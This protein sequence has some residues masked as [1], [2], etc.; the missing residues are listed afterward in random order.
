MSVL[1]LFVAIIAV[2]TLWFS[3]A[4]SNEIGEVATTNNKQLRVEIRFDDEGVN[5][6]DLSNLFKGGHLVRP[7][8]GSIDEM[9]GWSYR[10]LRRLGEGE[11]VI[12]R[13]RVGIPLDTGPRLTYQVSYEWAIKK[14]ATEKLM[15]VEIS[16]YEH[17]AKLL[18][19]WKY[20]QHED[21]LVSTLVSPGQNS[22]DGRLTGWT[23]GEL[24]ELGEGKHSIQRKRIGAKFEWK[25]RT[26]QLK[27]P[28][29]SS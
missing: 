4:Y 28:D 8:P 13:Q 16:R 23:Y 1:R 10:E 19:T 20:A 2:S 22:F 12:N 5:V 7:G 3:G 21:C 18:V 26:M 24:A 6:R 9:T 25:D 27:A 14:F 29:I 11:H 17:T 15:S